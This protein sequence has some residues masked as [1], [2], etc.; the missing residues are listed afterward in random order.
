M[1]AVGLNFK[2]PVLNPQLEDIEAEI[3]YLLIRE[4]ARAVGT[5]AK[6]DGSI[7][8]T[9]VKE[10]SRMVGEVLHDKDRALDLNSSWH[11]LSIGDSIGHGVEEM[12]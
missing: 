3:T 12:D 5:P 2:K 4:L 1:H 10:A 8:L 7:D 9:Y 11:K 6:E